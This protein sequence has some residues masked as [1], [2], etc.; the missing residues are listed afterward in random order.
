MKKIPYSATTKAG[1]EKNG[2]VTAASNKDALK[3]LNDQGYTNIKLHDDSSTA[4]RR[5]DLD[6]LS[7]RELEQ[8]AKL[9][10][11]ARTRTSL[12]TCLIE[13]IRLNWII[14]VLGIGLSM[15]GYTDQSS[16][17]LVIGLAVTLSMP[18][19]TT[20]NYR[21]VTGYNNLLN[22]F[23]MGEWLEARQYIEQLRPKMKLPE[24]AFDLDIREA[25][26]LASEGDLRG[27]LELVEKW[28][29]VFE[30]DSPGTFE[31]RI[32][33][34]YHAAGDYQGFLERMKEGYFKS[35]S[36]SVLMLD[37][38]LA[39]AR[40][41][42]ADRAELLLGKIVV[43]ELPPQGIPFLDWV[44]GL[45]A[46]RKSDP[47]SSSYLAGAVSGFLEYSENPAVLTSLALCSGSYAYSLILHGDRD[48]AKSVVERVWP[49]LKAHGDLMLVTELTGLVDV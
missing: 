8:I 18:L 49:I 30:T 17:L 21:T 13:T 48:G 6:G 5:E 41:G 9:E 23:A 46:I 35:T 33:P 2:F 40:F 14:V 34:I 15:W 38:C 16:V 28:R 19:L 11:K 47:A 31:S 27:A 42:E 45:I 12:V 32:A 20:W 37:L 1:K 44:K 4:F 43:E 3:A 24:M 36:S 26:I 29:E 10:I 7:E 22:S 25:S 39:E